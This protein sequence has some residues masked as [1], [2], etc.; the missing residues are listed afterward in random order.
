MKQIYTPSIN[1]SILQREVAEFEKQIELVSRTC[2]TLE[3][4]RNALYEIAQMF[5][6][7]LKLLSGAVS[8][9]KFFENKLRKIAYCDSIRIMQTK[10]FEFT[11]FYDDNLINESA[12]QVFEFGKIRVIWKPSMVAPENAVSKEKVQRI[13]EIFASVNGVFKAAVEGREFSND[14]R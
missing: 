10:A 4:E 13:F 8:F 14:F 5:I 7:I 11:V 2:E 12:I 6:D 1:P 3:D 9:C